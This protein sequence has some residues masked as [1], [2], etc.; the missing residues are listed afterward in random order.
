M[1]R[2]E[3][4]LTLSIL[5]FFFLGLAVPQAILPVFLVLLV[6]VYKNMP[7]STLRLQ[8]TFSV[9]AVT[10]AGLIGGYLS[11]FDTATEAGLPIF[12]SASFRALDIW[13]LLN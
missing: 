13:Y 12:Y 10:L 2:K 4:L 7:S 9:L 3:I 8:Y 5:L 1:N 6:V 11:A